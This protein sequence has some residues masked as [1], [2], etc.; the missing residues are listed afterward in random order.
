MYYTVSKTSKLKSGVHG[1]PTFGTCY[2]FNTKTIAF[3]I[4]HRRSLKRVKKK[5]LCWQEKKTFL[6]NETAHALFLSRNAQLY[7]NQVPLF[8]LS[9]GVK[10]KIDTYASYALYTMLK[11]N[12]PNWVKDRR[13]D[14]TVAYHTSSTM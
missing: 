10:Q 14:N 5:K 12:T 4:L 1:V 6:H 9:P 13:R 7:E 11:K 2:N 3:F 8:R